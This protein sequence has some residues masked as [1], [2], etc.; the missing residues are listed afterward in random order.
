MGS[1]IELKNVTFEYK[2]SGEENRVVRALDRVD[3]AIEE[4]SFTGRPR[5]CSA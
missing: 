4:G 5:L 2:S 1:I 3:L